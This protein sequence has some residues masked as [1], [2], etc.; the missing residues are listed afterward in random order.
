MPL[1]MSPKGKTYR[2]GQTNESSRS[3]S[4]PNLLSHTPQ[5]PPFPDK[6]ECVK[7]DMCLSVKQDGTVTIPS[8]EGQY[9]QDQHDYLRGRGCD[10]RSS[11]CLLTRLDA[12]QS[13][14]M[15]FLSVLLVFDK[16]DIT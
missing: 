8:F 10:H 2:E 15:L 9:P 16:L 4:C 6:D 13:S 11:E 7:Q 1:S 14:G 3:K 5:N 12:C